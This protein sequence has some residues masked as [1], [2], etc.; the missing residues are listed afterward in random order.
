MVAERLVGEAD[1]STLDT[2]STVNRSLGWRFRTSSAGKKVTRSFVKVTRSAG[3]GGE[4]TFAFGTPANPDQSDGGQWYALGCQFRPG[5]DGYVS[6]GDWFCS[7]N[8]PAGSQQMALY[9]VADKGL[10]AISTTFVATPASLNR[11]LFPAPYRVTAGVD[12]VIAILTNRYA[13]TLGGWPYTTSNLEAF[14][15]VNGRFFET[16][17]GVMAYPDNRNPSAANYHISPIY[18][19]ES[20]FVAGTKWQLWKAAIPISSSTLLQNVEIGSGA[21][22]GIGYTWQEVPGISQT[23]L[24]QNDDYFTNIYHPGSDPGNYIYKS[25]FGDPTSGSLSGNNIFKN[26]G[27]ATDPPDD[28]TFNDGAFAVDIEID[29]AGGTFQV[30][31]QVTET[32]EVFSIAR[33]KIYALNFATE[34][35]IVQTPTRVKARD[36]AQIMETGTVLGVG[37]VK[38]TTLGQVSEAGTVFDVDSAKATTL[39]QVVETGTAFGVSGPNLVTAEIGQVLEFGTPG[40]LGPVPEIDTHIVREIGFTEIQF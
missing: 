19:E 38:A 34:T 20:T 32:G 5:A 21:I 8:G 3:V 39:G 35:G 10:V 13:Y 15:A 23:S 28:E 7:S 17:P 37:A 14:N 40:R 31:G 33:N 24:V 9:T 11:K 29:D 22:K 30:I 26:N 18:D 25:S 6:G 36:L 12:Y 1:I 4:E 27:A 2:I 16:S